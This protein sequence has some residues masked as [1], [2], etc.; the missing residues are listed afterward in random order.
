MTEKRLAVAPM[1][2]WTDRHCRSFYRLLTKEAVLYTEM[3]TTGA[4]LHGDQARHL[5]YSA[6]EHPVVLQLGG[7]EPSDLAKCAELAHQ[8]GYDEIDLNC[9]CPSE[10]VQKGAF[11]ACLMAEPDLVA[12]CVRAM[13]A[14]CDLPISV[15][16]RLGLDAMNAAQSDDDYR[17]VLD[18]ILA[19][20]DAGAHQVTIHARNAVL[21]GLSPKENRTKPPLHYEIAK[22]LRTDAQKVFPNLKVL[23]NGGLESNQHI[24]NHW[25]DFD[26]FMIGRAAYH[27][28]AMLLG[29]D[30]LLKSNGQA[31]GYLFSEADW[32]RVQIGLVSQAQLW[33]ELCQVMRKPFYLGAITR[34][35]MGLAHGRAGS[36]RWRQRLSDHHVLAQVKSKEAI[37]S[38]FLEASLELGDWA[39]FDLNANQAS[40]MSGA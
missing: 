10:R 34:H 19:V 18:F 22:Q 30:A 40:L 23:L 26:G 36:R 9:G 5:D 29:W 12:Q 16:Q 28:P 31:V 1:M 39:A 24:A 25:N 21:K 20:A 35:M 11:G 14:A 6:I 2:E 7:S 38:F 33:L 27:F 32:H 3:L 37:E 4:L 15:K 13:R 8:W 17:F